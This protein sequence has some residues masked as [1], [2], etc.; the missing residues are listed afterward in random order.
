MVSSDGCLEQEGA[1]VK[2]WLNLGSLWKCDTPAVISRAARETY[3][4]C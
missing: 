4:V 2:K 3:F 1:G